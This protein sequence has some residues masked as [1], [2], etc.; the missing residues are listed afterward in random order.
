MPEIKP[1]SPRPQNLKQNSSS[2]K[3]IPQQAKNSLSPIPYKEK[4]DSEEEE[5][6]K[7]VENSTQPSDI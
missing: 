2:K 1:I 4:V 7:T 6:E 5:D 3:K